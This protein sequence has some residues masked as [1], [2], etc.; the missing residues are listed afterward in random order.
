MVR[1]GHALGLAHTANFDDIMYNFQYGGDI[2]EYFACY[3]RI[4]TRREDIPKHPGISPNGQKRL[5]AG[6]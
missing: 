3:A 4:L 1:T 5:A 2:A 6:L